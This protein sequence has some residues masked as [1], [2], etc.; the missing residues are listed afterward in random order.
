MKLIDKLPYFYEEC[1]KTNTIQD[2]LGSETLEYKFSVSEPKPS[3]IVLVLG[4]S[5]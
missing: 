5:S 1:P 3:C 2:G 4:H